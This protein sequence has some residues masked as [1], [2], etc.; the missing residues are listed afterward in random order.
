MTRRVEAPLVAVPAKA[1]PLF[2]VAPG[3]LEFAVADGAWVEAGDV[4][5]RLANPELELAVAA[6]EGAVRERRV[7]LSQ[8]RTLQAVLPAAAR[9][10]PTAAAE[11]ADAEAQLAEQQAMVEKLVIRAPAAGRV[12]APPPRPAERGADGH[13]AAVE[14]FAAGASAIAAPGSK[15]ER[16]WR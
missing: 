2:A 6:A 15:R 7:R 12:L 11:L 5:A 13:A 10:L 9:M 4:V 8:L 14:R 3:E 1:H 16:R